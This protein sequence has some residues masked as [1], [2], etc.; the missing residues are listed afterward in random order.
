MITVAASDLFSA[1]P[2]VRFAA[3]TSSKQNR[4]VADWP[5]GCRG[6]A[7]GW[8]MLL[9]PSPGRQ[10]SDDDIWLG[11]PHR[12]QD[13]AACIGPTAGV[14]RYETNKGR[15]RRW[16]MLS[17][18][19][20]GRLDYAQALT[21]IMNL[22]WGHHP[23]SSKIPDAYLRDGCMVVYELMKESRPRVVV[24]LVR[25]TW[26]VFVPF[27]TTIVSPE[28][29]RRATQLGSVVVRLP[30]AGAATLVVRAPQHPSRHFF[31]AGHAEL[32]RAETARF[33][34]QYPP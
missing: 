5:R 16:N 19:V 8:M 22:D 7:N 27:L 31:N 1:D 20:F 30:N 26:D 13:E 15:N 9:G 3:S 29:Y 24:T 14:V 17:E 2:A 28:P 32:L 4:H 21:S 34:L 18:A 25:R 6:A 11:G 12:P 10:D 33:L 23:D